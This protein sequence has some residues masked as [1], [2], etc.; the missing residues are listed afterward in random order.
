MSHVSHELHDE[1]PD[2]LA[3]LHRLKLSSPHFRTLAERH[4]ALNHEINRI[5]AGLDPA[6]DERTETLKKSRLALLDQVA[7]MLDEAAN[8]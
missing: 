2:H 6:S 5:E 8:G 7:N 4:H 1:F 3:T